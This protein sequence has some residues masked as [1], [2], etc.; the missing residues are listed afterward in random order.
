MAFS[1]Q[2]CPYR[3]IC[4]SASVLLDNSTVRLEPGSIPLGRLK[5]ARTAFS[6]ALSGPDCNS[7]LDSWYLRL[8][9]GLINP[10]R[11]TK[12]TQPWFTSPDDLPKADLVS[13]CY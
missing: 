5:A 4:I 8:L 3:E 11:A 13:K 2:E 10:L 12:N 7:G 9:P 6:R 1:R